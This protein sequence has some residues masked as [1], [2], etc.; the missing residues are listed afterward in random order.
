MNT[1]TQRVSSADRLEFTAISWL[2]YQKDPTRKFRDT[3][4]GCV[5]P[6]ELRNVSFGNSSDP[7]GTR[8]ARVIF[9]VV[10]R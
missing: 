7:L 10:T 4:Y 8:G 2:L 3:L 1:Y 6:G 9:N 5:G